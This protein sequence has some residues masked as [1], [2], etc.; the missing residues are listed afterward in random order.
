MRQITEQ[1][2]T[3]RDPQNQEHLSRRSIL[4]GGLAVTLMPIPLTEALATPEE[5]ADAIKDVVGPAEISDGRV[6][7]VMPELAENGNSVQLTVTVDSP[8]TPADHVKTIHIFSEQNPIATVVRFHLGPRCGQAKVSTSIRLATTQRIVA[9][10]EMNNG[11]FWRGQANIL[12]TL[13]A[14]IDGG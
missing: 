10:A 1:P 4:A 12:V 13:A 7:L 2:V 8:M 6:K 3:T 9:L 11:T 5:M 14:C